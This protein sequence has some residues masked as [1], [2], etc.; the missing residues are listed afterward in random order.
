MK[1]WLISVAAI[2]IATSC[3]EILLPSGKIKNSCKTVLAM[4]CVAVFAQP[5]INLS[6]L[7]VDFS[8]AFEYDGVDLNYVQSTEQYYCDIFES[9][10]VLFLDKKGVICTECS[11][12]GNL[13]DGNFTV[14]KVFVKVEKS[15]ICGEDEHIIS[16]VEIKS[17]LAA[18]LALPIEKVE[19]YEC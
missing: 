15:V 3:S 6:G 12:T 17:M 1:S 19:V 9:E 16:I 4:V 5:L 14:E 18:E 7:T 10:V 13:T 11:V 2:I 8:Q